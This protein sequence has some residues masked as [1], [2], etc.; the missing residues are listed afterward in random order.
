MSGP[1]P[2]RLRDGLCGEYLKDCGLSR[3]GEVEEVAALAA[4]HAIENACVTGQ[5]MMVDGGL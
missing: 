1:R 5:T 3:H 2:A 4:W